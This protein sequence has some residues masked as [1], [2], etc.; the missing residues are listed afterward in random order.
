MCFH[1]YV[2]EHILSRE[3]WQQCPVA[4]DDDLVCCQR[5]DDTG[6]R[7]RGELHLLL[8]GDPGNRNVSLFT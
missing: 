1:W 6:S 4:H 2:S 8:V 3:E 7:V 5:V